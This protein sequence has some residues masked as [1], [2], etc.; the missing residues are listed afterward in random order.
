MDEK[1][2]IDCDFH[3]CTLEYSGGPVTFLETAFMRCR[4]SFSGSAHRTLTKALTVSSANQPVRS[5]RAGQE[6]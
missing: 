6:R 4:W 2:F 1:N 5:V 3:D